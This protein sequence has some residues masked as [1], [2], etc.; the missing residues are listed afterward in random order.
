M[1][2]YDEPKHNKTSR[3]VVI[4]NVV[5]HEIVHQ[6]EPARYYD[7][8]GMFNMLTY[9]KAAYGIY[10]MYRTMGE[11]RMR[12]MLQNA[13]AYYQSL[14]AEPER[15]LKLAGA[16]QDDDDRKTELAT[17]EEEELQHVLDE[18]DELKLELTVGRRTSDDKDAAWRVFEK[19]VLAACPAGMQTSTCSNLDYAPDERSKLFEGIIG[20]IA[21]DLE[22][23]Q[24]AALRQSPEL[25]EELR[26]MPKWDSAMEAYKVDRQWRHNYALDILA[27]FAK[28]PQIEPKEN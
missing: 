12:N 20:G 17:S 2:L 14:A 3:R 7:I 21:S 1:I 19:E 13:G 16:D 22:L 24:V 11:E 15:S 4:E 10:T 23:A 6:R 18:V 27:K 25:T 9:E 28:L 5:A 26:R 8:R